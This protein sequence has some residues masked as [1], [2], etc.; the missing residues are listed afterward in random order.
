[1]YDD[2]E[3][4]WLEGRDSRTVVAR[5]A[6]THGDSAAPA[7]KP[8]VCTC[9]CTGCWHTRAACTCPAG[10]VGEPSSSCPE[11]GWMIEEAQR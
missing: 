5:Q 3:A 7:G 4:G 6:E 8:V 1:M 11:H 2:A 10:P 9:L